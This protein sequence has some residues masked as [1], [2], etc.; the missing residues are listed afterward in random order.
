MGGMVAVE[1]DSVGYKLSPTEIATAEESSEV[2]EEV[3]PPIR[4]VSR[5]NA[6]QGGWYTDGNGERYWRTK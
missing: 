1:A 3:E 2:E 5:W 6:G 4:R